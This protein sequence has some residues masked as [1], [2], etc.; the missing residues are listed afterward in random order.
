MPFIYLRRF[1]GMDIN[2]KTNSFHSPKRCFWK[3]IKKT[4]E[5][6]HWDADSALVVWARTIACICL[7]NVSFSFSFASPR[8]LLLVLGLSLPFSLYY[9]HCPVV[10]AL[11]PSCYCPALVYLFKCSLP[12]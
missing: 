3:R 4:I 11:T 2:K 7:K 10:F 6:R 9:L 12:S 1:S 8:L 5:A